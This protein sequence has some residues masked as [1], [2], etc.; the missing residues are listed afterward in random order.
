MLCSIIIRKELVY[1]NK[2]QMCHHGFFSARDEN[3]LD[4]FVFKLTKVWALLD[5]NSSGFWTFIV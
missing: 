4:F 1:M 5:P 3:N 2:I